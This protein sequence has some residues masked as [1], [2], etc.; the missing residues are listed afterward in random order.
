MSDFAVRRWTTGKRL[1]DIMAM[2]HAAFREFEPPSGVLKETAADLA[3]RQRRGLI[4]VA[5][6]GERFIGSVFAARKGD[7]FYLTRLATAPAWRKRGVGRA[8]MA[9]AEQEASASGAARLTLRVRQTLPGNLAY[10]RRLGFVVTGEGREDGR[11]PF[12][13]MERMLA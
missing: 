5:M 9:A 4:L 13:T 10:F 6:D 12:H 1:G 8:L 3:A 2:V 7:A 11:T